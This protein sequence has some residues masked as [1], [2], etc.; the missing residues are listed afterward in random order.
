MKTGNVKIDYCEKRKRQGKTNGIQAGTNPPEKTK[1]TEGKI[2]TRKQRQAE[3]NSHD[4]HKRAKRTKGTKSRSQ[5]SQTVR[6]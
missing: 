6:Q 2:R 4:K 5:M 1:E 3:T